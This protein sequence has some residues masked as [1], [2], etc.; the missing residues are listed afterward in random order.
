MIAQ[1]LLWL[2]VFVHQFGYLGIFIM[3]L[4]ESTFV[5]IPAEFTV[6]PAGY[7]VQQ[8][9]MNGALVFAASVFGTLT[10][11][12]INYWFAYHFGRRA[13]IRFGKYFF[14]S[15]ERLNHVETFFVVHGAISTFTG[16][17]ILGVR[18]FIAF[19]AGLGRMKLK[20]FILYTLAG[21]AIWNAVL[22]GVGYLIGS[23][24]ELITHYLLFIKLGFAMVAVMAIIL[25]VRNHRRKLE[26]K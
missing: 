22:I 24:Q 19:P 5:P 13:I 16:R 12:L 9:E 1:L 7:L 14:L 2:V 11:S 17:L 18:H 6:V 21:G 3:T 26:A 10:G 8:S 23:N 20:S 4:L 25:Y 15:E